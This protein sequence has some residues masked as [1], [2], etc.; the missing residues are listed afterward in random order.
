MPAHG[1]VWLAQVTNPIRQSK[2]L[3]RAASAAPINDL[4]QGGSFSMSAYARIALFATATAF[5]LGMLLASPGTH[6]QGT[7]AKDD[8]KKEEMKKDTMKKD[9]M[10][11]DMKK[12]DKKDMMKKDDMKK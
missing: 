11:K 5:S 6:A 9:S 10:S 7:M 12:D 3:H 4:L 1:N 8:M 2:H